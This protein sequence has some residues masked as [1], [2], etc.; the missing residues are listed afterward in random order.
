[1]GGSTHQPWHWPLGRL[2]YHLI[3]L[4]SKAAVDDEEFELNQL[5]SEYSRQIESDY[6]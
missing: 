1:M 4:R 3:Q 5:V 6:C 2:K